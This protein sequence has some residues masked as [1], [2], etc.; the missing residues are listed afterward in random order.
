MMNLDYLNCD[1]SEQWVHVDNLE[2]YDYAKEWI[3]E[4]VHHMYNTGDVDEMEN[5]LDELLAIFS[6]KLPP[7]SPKI[8]K[9]QSNLFNFAIDL[10]RS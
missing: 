7:N 9:K 1:E 8:Q 2:K 3:D 4:V 6:G 10:S 5:A